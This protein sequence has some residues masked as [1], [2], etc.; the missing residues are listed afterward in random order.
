MCE[1]VCVSALS[2]VTS[3]LLS[4]SSLSLQASEQELQWVIRV[5]M[6]LVGLAGTG[7][8]FGDDSV[9]SLWLLSGDLLYCMILPQLICVLHIS[10]ANSYGAISGFVVGLLLRVLSGEPALGIPPLLLYPGWREESGVITQYFP[11]RTLTMLCSVICIIVVS[12][13]VDLGFCHQLIPQSWDL[14]LTL[15]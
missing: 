13:L 15:L 11:Y 12:K 9:L 10:C 6:L 7:L 2:K 3:F 14:P 4:L 1:C 8:A 5:S